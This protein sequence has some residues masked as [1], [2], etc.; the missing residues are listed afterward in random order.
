[1]AELVPAAP[2]IAAPRIAPQGVAPGGIATLGIDTMSPAAIDQVRRLEDA[3]LQLPQ[4]AI[5]TGHVLHAGLYAR[6]IR[7][8]A[9]VLLTGALIRIATLLVVE[10]DVVVFVDGEPLEL[11]GYHVLPAAAGR[12]QALLARADTHLTMIFATRATSVAEAEA[13]F[14]DE[15]DR[16]AS[17]RQGRRNV[18]IITGEHACQ[19]E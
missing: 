9:G 11:T 15:A 6:T 7:I 13:E 16:L 1:M 14:T 4:V 10:G 5:E 18:V 8:P 19:E 3:A 17:R 12:K 2:R